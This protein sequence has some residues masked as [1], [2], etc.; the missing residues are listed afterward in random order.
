MRAYQ[1][2]KGGGVEGLA[3]VELPDPQPGPGDVLIRVKSTSLNYRD[4]GQARASANEIIPLSDGAGEV[5][6]I[7]PGVRRFS[8]G[9]RVMGCFFTEWMD[10]EITNAY[11]RESLGGG[12]TNG[13]LAELVVLPERA[14]IATPAHLTD[15]EAAT[16]PCAALTAWHAIF[17]QA[18][19]RPGQAV[20]FLGTGGV[21]ISGLQ[22]AKAAGF[23][24]IIT[25]S[26]D[27]KLERARAL[28]AH[29]TINYRTTPDWEQAVLEMT[30]GRGVDLVLEV[31]GAGTFGKSNAAVRVNGSMVVIGGLASE[32]VTEVP[33]IN[34]NVH[35]T[36]IFVGSRRMFE[37]MNRAISLHEIHPVI[38]RVFPFEQTIEA[39]RYLESQA[40]FGKIV[41]RV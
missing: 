23:R 33:L 36:R 27:E 35:A 31:G 11:I 38:G 32:G 22:L 8:V 4:L 2:T 30:D 18:S 24:T 29:G 41:I 28:G 3:R 13:M 34:R 17:E 7:G 16:L 19:L 26:S 10:G 39:Y 5:V 25:S 9:D 6:A 12:R 40:H 37:D 14:V 1:I 15:D 21:S 20:L